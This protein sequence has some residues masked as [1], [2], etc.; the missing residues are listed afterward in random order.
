ML[1]F[2][3]RPCQMLTGY[4]HTENRTCSDTA[5]RAMPK[6]SSEDKMLAHDIPC[7]CLAQHVIMGFILV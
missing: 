4:K 5:Y 7:V 3:V 6:G 2:K 1:S